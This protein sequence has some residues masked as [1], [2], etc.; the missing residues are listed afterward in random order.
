MNQKRLSRGVLRLR[1]TVLR[2]TGVTG[3]LAVLA[4]VVACT[5]CAPVG[6]HQ[7]RWVSKPN[8]TFAEST[9]FGYQHKLLPQVEPGTASSGGA[10]SSGCTSCK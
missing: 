7:Q 9:V 6:V 10:Q 2:V 3:P 8:M 4:A 1:S 5:G